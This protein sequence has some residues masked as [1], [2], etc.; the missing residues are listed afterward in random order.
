MFSPKNIIYNIIFKLLSIL[1]AVDSKIFST[2]VRSSRFVKELKLN[3]DKVNIHAH[4]VDSLS[5][6]IQNSKGF[7]FRL[8]C[9]EIHSHERF[10]STK[11][12]LELSKI[13]NHKKLIK[14]TAHNIINRNHDKNLYLGVHIRRADYIS[15]WGGEFYFSDATYKK[16]INDLVDTYGGKKNIKIVIVSDDTINI[17]M[18]SDLDYIYL[19]NNDPAVDQALLQKCDIII[20]PLSTFSGWCS[21]IKNIPW[22]IMM[23]NYTLSWEKLAP[24]EGYITL[25]E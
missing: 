9:G 18:F 4:V 11:D 15:Y 2:I 7:L 24:C 3:Y 17:A 5:K 22:G 6:Q 25:P 20:G 14:N 12:R 13:F 16:F 19:K 1:N 8:E 21:F 10:I 23:N